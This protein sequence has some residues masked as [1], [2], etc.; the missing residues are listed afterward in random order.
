MAESVARKPATPAL[1][2]QGY[3]GAGSGLLV[4]LDSLAPG[5]MVRIPSGLSEFDRVLGG[6]IVAGSSIVL[7]GNPGA[8]KSTLLLQTGCS[9]A[10]ERGVIYCT[11]EESLEQ[12]KDHATRLGL[13][14]DR[15]RAIVETDVVTIGSFME[16]ERPDLVI[17]D[18]IQSVFHPEL[19][20]EPGSVSQL[21]TCAGYLNRF[22][23]RLGTAIVFVGHITKSEAIAGPMTLIH[24]VDAVAHLSSTDDARYRI[25]RADK[26]RFGSASEI[27]VFA[28]TGT[29]LKVVENPSAIFL[30]RAVEDAAGT[31]VTPLWQGTRPMLVE[32]QALAD[33][34]AQGNPRRVGVGLDDKRLAML[35]AVLHRHGG[36]HVHD[37]DV[38]ANVVGGIKVIETSADLPVLLSVASSL[39]E[40]SIP[41][42]IIVFGE[43][44]LSGEVRPC[45][46]GSDRLREAA[47]L[48]FKRAVVPLANCPRE[49]VPGLDLFPVSTLVQALEWLDNL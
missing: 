34:G 20:S 22:A 24:L 39:K 18:S 30:S 49:G 9:V 19:D 37:A 45:Q 35:L 5:S 48:G 21:R 43:V 2:R 6:G 33:A 25:M 29:G 12:I 7:S 40:K 13:P 8:G 38:Y 23:K 26:N 44:G 47:K 28:M 14:Q 31:V 10:R 42:D 32:V 46:N 16:R 4:T 41:S 15:M 3:A 17:V 27:G 36:V 1:A 11:G